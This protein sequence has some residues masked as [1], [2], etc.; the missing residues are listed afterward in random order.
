MLK[1]GNRVIKYEDTFG[2][3]IGYR[4][5]PIGNLSAITY[6]DGTEVSYEYDN[7][8]RVISTVEKNAR[9]VLITGFEYT[10]DIL[11]RVSTE[12]H[13]DKNTK[14]CYTYDER[15]RVASKTVVPN[16]AYKGMKTFVD[17]IDEF[18]EKPFL[19]KM[20]SNSPYDDFPLRR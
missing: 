20:I 14:L 4:Y 19:V 16:R 11:G 15:S 13:L 10:Y 18:M 3:V 9:G 6:P 17:E 8:G 7:A 12:T 2:N 1:I 5:D